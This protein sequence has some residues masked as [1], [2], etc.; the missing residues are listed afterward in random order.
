MT[1][2]NFTFFKLLENQIIKN[3]VCKVIISE[4]DQR[5]DTP[6]QLLK[7]FKQLECALVK[8]LPGC[9]A[10]WCLFVTAASSVRH[11]EMIPFHLPDFIGSI[12]CLQELIN[13]TPHL[14]VLCINALQ[15]N[16]LY[17]DRCII[18]LLHWILVDF[19]TPALRELQIEELG[20]LMEKIQQR[21]NDRFP[22][23]AFKVNYS[24]GCEEEKTFK[25]ISSNHDTRYAFLGCKSDHF[26]RILRDGF[27][28][29]EWNELNNKKI[30]LI[31]KLSTIL[32]LMP[33]T[34][35]FGNSCCCHALKIVALCEFVNRAEYLKSYSD[36]KLNSVQITIDQPDFVRVRYILFFSEPAAPISFMESFKQKML[37][38]SFGVP[39]W[40]NVLLFT[41]ITYSLGNSVKSVCMKAVRLLGNSLFY[42]L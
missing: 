1:E 6:V 11:E 32:R 19:N 12:N 30:N 33:Q 28:S 15:K 36:E 34:P 38:D 40:V 25:I 26:C 18:L 27:K 42:G 35:Y 10:K 31:C 5:K 39:N 22:I 16:Y 17:C 24:S 37:M 7:K 2:Y 21:N 41:A 13:E 20:K 23:K 8:D 9:L 4:S 29:C 3:G 14:H